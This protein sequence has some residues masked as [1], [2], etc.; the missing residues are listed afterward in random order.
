MFLKYYWLKHSKYKFRTTKCWF[1]LNYT[2][3]YKLKCFVYPTYISHS[4]DTCTAAIKNRNMHAVPT[5][6]VAD[7]LLFNDNAY[8]ICF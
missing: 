8:N 6:Q 3:M 5:N 1:T 7:I 4:I 2:C